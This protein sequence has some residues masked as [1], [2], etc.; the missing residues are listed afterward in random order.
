MYKD[1]RRWCVEKIVTPNWLVNYSLLSH[2]YLRVVG[3]TL[4]TPENAPVKVAGTA[5]RDLSLK[6]KST[7]SWDVRGYLGIY[8][9]LNL[10]G[11]MALTIRHTEITPYYT[12]TDNLIITLRYSSCSSSGTPLVLNNSTVITD[13]SFGDGTYTLPRGGLQAFTVLAVKNLCPF[14]F[15]CAWWFHC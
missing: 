8:L 14:K 10:V 15:W 3:S 4:T 5:R 1:S 7:M 12:L 9:I 13:I 2:V 6:Q 11:E